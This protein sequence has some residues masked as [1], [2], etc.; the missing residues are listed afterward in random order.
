MVCIAHDPAKQRRE[1]RERVDD[2]YLRLW[3]P[4]ENFLG[5]RA[6]GRHM[7]FADRGGENEHADPIRSRARF[8]AVRGFV[9]DGSG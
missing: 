4:A 1:C 7:T 2:L 9:H 3:V 6:C 5:Q 8:G